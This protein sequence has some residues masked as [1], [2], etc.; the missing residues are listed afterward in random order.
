MSHSFVSQFHY[1]SDNL[2]NN[3]F[4]VKTPTSQLSSPQNRVHGDMSELTQKQGIPGYFTQPP[5]FNGAY[6]A[7]ASCTNKRGRFK[8]YSILNTTVSLRAV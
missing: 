4:Q 1:Q 5:S 8:T 6:V 2:A 7:E 3:L